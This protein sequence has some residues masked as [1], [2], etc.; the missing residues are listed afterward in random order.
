M[1]KFVF[2]MAF[3]AITLAS[4]SNNEDAPQMPEEALVP[5]QPSAVTDVL[6]T[7]E[8]TRA[9]IAANAVASLLIW[10]STAAAANDTYFGANDPKYQST[11]TLANVTGTN[12]ANLTL[13]PAR[14]Y[15]AEATI[16]S[17][18]AGVYPKLEAG[19]MTNAA[20]A[21][22]VVTVAKQDGTVDVCAAVM[23]NGNKSNPFSA[24]NGLLEF[25]HKTAK[26]VFKA[27]KD[28]TAVG[29]P[30]LTEIVIN[31][32]KVPSKLT[33]T[34]SAVNVTDVAATALAKAY[35]NTT[36]M[37]LTTTAAAVNGTPLF[38]RPGVTSGTGSITL[39]VKTKSGTQET[40]YT[41]VPLTIS[42]NKIE[43]GKQYEITLTFKQKEITP[44]VKVVPWTATVPGTSDVM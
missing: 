39:T 2:T 28:A 4:C 21:K 18:I 43:E 41:N 35:S 14:Y 3:A 42:G 27:K 38:I 12:N 15:N 44:T 25:N 9:E 37:T 6:E 1:K 32:A 36:G 23:K 11:V 29:D 24:T 22:N 19:V 34:S 26:I 17:Y 8:G 10:E 7:S 16:N 33:F 31:N 5:I 13:T 40:T 20:G 30:K